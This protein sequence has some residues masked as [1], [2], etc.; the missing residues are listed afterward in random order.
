[1]YKLIKCAGLPQGQESLEKSGKKGVFEK[2]VRFFQLKFTKFLN[3][4]SLSM[5][6][7]N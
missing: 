4:Q 2:K 5:V 3:F 6:K 7:I 1:M